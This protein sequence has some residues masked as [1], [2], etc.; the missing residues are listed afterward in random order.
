MLTIYLLRHGETRWNAEGNKYCGRTDLPLTEK[1][2][3][4]AE[5][6]H[7]KLKGITFDA[8]YSSP[9]KR[10]LH[11]ARIVSGRSDVTTDSRLQEVDFGLWEGKP[12]EVFIPENKALWQ[13]WITDPTNVQAGATGETAGQVVNRVDSFFQ[14]LVADR[15]GQTILVTGHN[16]VNRLFLSYKLEMPLKNYQKFYLDNASVTIFTLDDKGAMILRSLNK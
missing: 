2:I 11:T 1:G 6:V 9:L 4:Q 14:S 3:D 7:R 12:K 13:S 15:Q 5:S 10:S 8:C 16:G